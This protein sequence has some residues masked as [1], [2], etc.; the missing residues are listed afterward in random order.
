MGATPSGSALLRRDGPVTCAN[1][2]LAA[3]LAD[4]LPRNQRLLQCCVGLHHCE[5]GLWLQST[6]SPLHLP[7]VS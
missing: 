7:C 2:I 5:K 4:G 6:S 3:V 1:P